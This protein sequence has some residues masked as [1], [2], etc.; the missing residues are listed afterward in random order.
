M[1]EKRKPLT[2]VKPS[3]MEIICFYPCP[4][5][6]REVP[7]V[8]PTQP[9]MVRCDACGKD[10]PIVPVDERGVRFFKVMTANGRAAVDP[11]FL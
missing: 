3:G 4:F 7:L 11:D 5:C 2:P 8:S 10:F 9:A 6:S 1:G